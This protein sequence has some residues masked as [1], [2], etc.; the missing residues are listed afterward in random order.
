L[1]LS[2]DL[3]I[4]RLVDIKWKIGGNGWT[5]AMYG[6][7]TKGSMT[8]IVNFMMEEMSFGIDS[9]FIDIGYFKKRW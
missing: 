1:N 2:K 9:K 6:E 8:K 7:L 3:F 4:D 5:G